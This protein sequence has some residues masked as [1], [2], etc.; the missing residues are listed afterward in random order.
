MGR[1]LA[2][3]KINAIKSAMM[4][5]DKNLL[6]ETEII[7]KQIDHEGQPKQSGDI[8]KMELSQIGVD[9]KAKTIQADVKKIEEM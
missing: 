3:D 1:S 2:Q 6:K 9:Q 8:H 5:L 4:Q 7:G